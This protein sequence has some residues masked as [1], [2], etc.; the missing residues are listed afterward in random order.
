[1]L[2]AWPS[3]ALCTSPLQVCATISAGKA[4]SERFT[5]GKPRHQ[6]SRLF[7]C[8]GEKNRTEEKPPRGVFSK[9]PLALEKR[10][11]TIQALTQLWKLAGTTDVKTNA[12]VLINPGLA[13]RSPSPPLPSQSRVAASFLFGARASLPTRF[14]MHFLPLLPANWALVLQG[15]NLCGCL[16]GVLAFAL[17]VFLA[18]SVPSRE[19]AIE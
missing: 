13:K 19:P 15:Q 7:P 10:G 14:Q 12:V 3:L 11:R 2:P 17:R 16:S 6:T 4:C 1:M 9:F 8:L 5:Q 18:S